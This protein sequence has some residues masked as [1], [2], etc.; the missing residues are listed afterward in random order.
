MSPPIYLDHNATS[1]LIPQAREA[2]SRALA[3]SESR[4]GNASSPHAFG[5]AARLAVEDARIEVAHLIGAE[6]REVIFVSGGTEA[7]NLAIQG[8]AR[9]MSEAGRGAGRVVTS[10]IEHPAV[11]GCCRR[12]Q[13][14]GWS[15]AILPVDGDGAVEQDEA[16]RALTGGAALVSVMAANNETGVLQPFETIARMAREAGSTIHVDAVQ[17]A[18]RIPID[19]KR[20]DIDLLSLSS[21][22]LGGPPGI[23]A[24]Y[25]REGV[26]LAPLILGGGQERKRRA[27]T[28]AP[29][30]A[31]G[32]AAA[33]RAARERAGDGASRIRDLRDRMESGLI[34]RIE[35]ARVNGAAAERLPN[36]TSL[37][38]PGA[39][40][41][42]LVIAMDL[43]GFALSTGSACSTGSSRPSHV[44]A[45]MG[46]STAEAVSTIRISLGPATTRAEIDAL[47]EALAGALIGARRAPSGGIATVRGGR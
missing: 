17:A 6:P 27:G 35:G 11:L 34:A 16:W 44:L 36:T 45:A 47:V 15:L 42:A 26:A 12:L 5:H 31:A 7:D 4:W 8:A 30:L 46:L 24:L 29:I 10:A 13:S 2:M 23:G 14:D 1:P 43:L 41:E 25:A 21:H 18:G 9:A 39:D 19:V 20:A 37:T 3:D 33:A 40:N 32:F 38:I 28:E 22:K